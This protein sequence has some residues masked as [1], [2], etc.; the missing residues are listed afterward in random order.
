MCFNK[1]WCN[2]DPFIHKS[3]PISQLIPRAVKVQILG[4]SLIFISLRLAKPERLI[5]IWDH[6]H[7]LSVYL[8]FCVYFYLTVWLV[9]L[10]VCTY[11]YL[12][13]CLFIYLL[14][15]LFACLSDCFSVWMPV[16]LTVWMRPE[17]LIVCLFVCLYIWLFACLPTGLK[18][19]DTKSVLNQTPCVN[20]I[21]HIISMYVAVSPKIIYKNNTLFRIQCAQ[22]F[23]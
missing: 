3:L 14:T 15:W 13:V 11:A 23:P 4:A 12:N 16:V 8:T 2:L 18:F 7:C 17:V 9:Y 20:K 21:N 6:M 1:N 19:E 10:I 5:I 22:C